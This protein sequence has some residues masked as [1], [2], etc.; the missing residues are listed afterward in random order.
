M[1]LKAAHELEAVD[2]KLARETYLDAW[3]AALFAGHLA[4]EG[5]LEDVSRAAT[6]APGPTQRPRPC[7]LLLDGLALLIIE[8]PA[9]A[10]ATARQ[11]CNAFASE[12]VSIE[13]KLR[14]GWLAPVPAAVLWDYETWYA[15]QARQVRFAR[16]AGFF[17]TL[18]VRLV[19][20]AC[21]FV[22]SGEF[23][24]AESLIGESEA[25]AE[26][27]GTRPL[28]Q[29][30]IALDALRGRGSVASTLVE[31]RIQG[32]V[33]GEG[34]LV[35]FA[36]WAASIRYNGLG[37]YEEALAA[38]RKAS[39]DAFAV[40]VS[41]WALPEQ[42]EAAVR[43]G[44][45]QLAADALERLAE[46]AAAGGTDWGLGIEARS[47]ALLSSGQIA[48]SL[49]RESIA[50]LSR[51]RLRPDLARAHLLYGEWLRREQRR[52]EAREQLRA[53]HSAF[54]AIGAEAFAE[55]ARLE[56]L[57]TGESVRKHTVEARD[58][59]TPQEAQIA[60]MAGDGHTNPEIGARL[61]LSPRTV[62]WHLRKV[63]TKLGVS[64]R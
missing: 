3:G 8:R 46:T 40:H 25:V 23:P 31:A 36:Q 20:L 2:V 27:M 5:S 15:M 47:R 62:E 63:F 16:D 33:E 53:A 37:R 64:S 19:A 10:A 22:L 43:V 59:L 26:A 35:S 57:A 24:A 29:G 42:V 18:P 44:N 54:G 32:A 50:R 9:A 58:E 56:L 21:C 39:G 60:R 55:R 30:P 11:A 1:L 41:G 12:D 51:T 48:D 52:V 6:A 28:P 17:A 38:A 4:K 14:W 61:F 34:H 45:A 13:E 49:Y 7:D